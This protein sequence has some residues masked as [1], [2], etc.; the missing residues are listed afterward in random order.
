M[1]KMALLY[2]ELKNFRIR[3]YYNAIANHVKQ[4]KTLSLKSG[5]NNLKTANMGKRI[6]FRF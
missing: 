5:Y 3:Y 1:H 2:K 4:K 6:G